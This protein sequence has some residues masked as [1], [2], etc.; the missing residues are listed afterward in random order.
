L[1]TIENG[2]VADEADSLA[3]GG[4]GDFFRDFFF[5][6]FE[7]AEFYFDKF[8]IVQGNINRLEQLLGD[9]FNA[10]DYEWF[11]MMCLSTQVFSL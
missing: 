9:A 10:Y 4:F 11:Y 2:D 5:G 3:F 8:V 1:L 6:L 7:F